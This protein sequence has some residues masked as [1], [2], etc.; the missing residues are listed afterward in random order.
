MDSPL[1][2]P[3]RMLW[4]ELTT[5]CPLSCVHCYNDSGPRGGHGTMSA[6]DWM[7]TLDQAAG[8]G[9]P[10]VQFIGGEPTRHPD[11]AG[12]IEH[13][14]ELGMHVEVYSNLVHVT[15]H[16]WELFTRPGVSL[17]TSWYSDDPDQHAAITGSRNAH[18]R[19][20][21]NI[22]EAVRRGVPIRVGLVG[23]IVTGQRLAEAKAEL[24]VLGVRN[25]RV[26]AMR[27]LG[28]APGSA[29]ADVTQLCGRCG[30]GIAAVLPDGSLAACPMARW[31]ATGDVRTSPLSDLL[32]RTSATARTFIR[33]AVADC[34]PHDGC[35]PPCEP[36]TGC[37]PSASEPD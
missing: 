28:R 22:A 10:H 4:L 25:V 30:D 31:L 26:D 2:A 23:G 13:A 24:A 29:S 27:G 12:L 17:A 14:L 9:I 18:H 33:P 15:D 21:A 37:D 7:A 16:Q 1:P 19:T 6:D 20:R 5:A 36:Q 11:L 3:P 34:A 35:D 32:E 8:L